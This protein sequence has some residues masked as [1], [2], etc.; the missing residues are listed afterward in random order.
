M[1]KPAGAVDPF[2]AR[3]SED[4]V[5]D[6]RNRLARA[7]WADEETVEDW[8][9]GVPLRWL[10]SLCEYWRTEYDMERVPRRL[11]SVPQL[12]VRVE[13]LRLHVVHAP[14]P[15]PGAL[16]LL[17]AH[18][19]PGSVLEFL[20]LV[21]ALTDPVRHGGSPDDAFSVV[22]PS[23][24]GYGFSD[25]PRTSGWGV[26]RIA[27]AFSEL[28][29]TLGYDRYGAAG[30]D[31]GTSVSTLLGVQDPA[32]VGIHLIPPL[33]G[34][35]PGAAQTPSERAAQEERRERAEDGGGYSAIQG[36]RPQTIG[37]SLV[38][39]PVGL[40][41]WIAEKYWAWT[42]HAGDLGAVLS[43]DELLDTVSLYWFTGTGAS[44]AR[45]YWE[46]IATVGRWISEPPD[47]PVRVPAGASVFG[48]EVPRPS[49][50]QAEARFTDLRYWSEHEHGGHF[51][52]I[53]APDLLVED[54]RAF[55]RTVR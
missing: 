14:S 51:A 11:N 38:D 46:S 19:W 29:A 3:I 47:E 43:R 13:G 8:S 15:H 18:G 48:R 34:P 22:I 41:A 16:P 45:L 37:Y 5:V 7:R 26:E 27:R 36:T 33:A 2:T 24:P 53:E 28:M 20:P 39:S 44:A 54:L 23:L 17:L 21:D 50:R 55:F 6:L 4:A 25:K 10:R 30:S 52:A 31:W 49:R 40:C 1:D 12:R 32:A 35:L 42:D 9:Q